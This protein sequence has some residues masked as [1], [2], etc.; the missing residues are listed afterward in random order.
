MIRTTTADGNQALLEKSAVRDLVAGLEGELF[1]P[2][3]AGYD[4]ARRVWNGMI[5]RYPGLV[6]RTAGVADVVRAVDFAREHNLLTAVRGGGHNV[7]GHGTTDGGLVIDLSLQNDVTVDPRARIVQ[8]GGGA[9]LGDV[10]SVTQEHGL[11]VPFGVVSQTGIAGLTLGGGLGWLRSRHGL[12]ADNLLA[13]QVVTPDGQ[14]VT[15]SEREN[16]DLLWGLRGGGGNFGIVTTFTYQAH[17]VGP[18]VFF[19]AV[20]HHGDAATEALKGSRDFNAA[21]PDEVATIAS[22]GIFPE[23]AEEY[24]EELHGLPFVA[25]V[26]MYAGPLDEGRRAMQP[27][28]E[29]SEPLVDFSGPMPYVQA[30]Q[31]FDAD[32]PAGDLRYYWKSLNLMELS[33]RAIATIVDHARSQPSQLSTT[34]LWPVRGAVKRVPDEETAFFGRR[35]AV[36]LNVEANWEDPG[37]DAA[38][39]AWARDAVAAVESFSDG[40]RYLNFAG[41]QEEGDAMMRAAF[42]PGYARLV[43]LKQTYDPTNFL[44]L[45]QNVKPSVS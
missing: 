22:L 26:G 12:T 44:R 39:V 11:A 23:G 16:P 3:D 17:P 1:G 5:D 32:Y 15:A 30:Q 42:G 43:E 4:E 21:A 8:A 6:V 13:A 45:N 29:L 7:A 40:S 37:A 36:V 31:F 19:T 27:L 2:D 14:V 18:E 41:F 35:A 28:R 24:P 9:T 34:D 33:D 10:D 20:F 25:F 38:N